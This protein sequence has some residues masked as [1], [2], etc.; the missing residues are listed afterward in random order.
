MFDDEDVTLAY[1]QEKSFSFQLDVCHSTSLMG[2]SRNV[3][4]ATQSIVYFVK[5][6]KRLHLTTMLVQI[7]HQGMKSGS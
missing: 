5:V 6:S 2:T 4:E 1:C 3:E 7:R